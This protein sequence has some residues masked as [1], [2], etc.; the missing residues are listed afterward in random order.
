MAAATS[1]LEGTLGTG[2]LRWHVYRSSKGIKDIKGI[3]QPNPSL[4]IGLGEDEAGGSRP[5]ASADR[6][7]LQVRPALA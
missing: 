1:S 4:K 2:T 3:A 7:R 5:V 6:H